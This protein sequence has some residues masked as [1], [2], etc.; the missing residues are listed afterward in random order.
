MGGALCHAE[1]A[2]RGRSSFRA[3]AGVGAEDGRGTRAGDEASIVLPGS[4]GELAS[5]RGWRDTGD[6]EHVGGG[7]SC[8]GCAEAPARTG[9]VLLARDAL[10]VRG[11]D[12]GGAG[13]AE[14]PWRAL[15]AQ[16]VV[17]VVCGE[18]LCLRAASR[19]LIGAHV[20]YYVPAQSMG[21]YDARDVRSQRGWAIPSRTRSETRILVYA[22]HVQRVVH[23][24]REKGRCSTSKRWRGRDAHGNA[25]GTHR[26][27]EDYTRVKHAHFLLTRACFQV[28]ERTGDGKT[29]VRGIAEA[30][31]K[32]NV[33][34]LIA[35]AATDDGA[36]QCQ[37]S[38]V[39]PKAQ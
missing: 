9:R 31:V 14:L 26:G 10:G 29:R 38:A 33:V 23:G 30:R 8:W 27:S 11:G 18:L 34:V 39:G 25:F 28:N 12:K 22:K 17:T 5:S 32:S 1:F 16:H 37:I 24:K 35:A 4:D 2:V 6:G 13:D 21:K 3:E 20:V 19:V 15:Q 7:P 36:I